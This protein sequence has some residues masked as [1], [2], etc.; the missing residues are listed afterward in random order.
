MN[1]HTVHATTYNNYFVVLRRGLPISEYFNT[2][3]DAQALA[4]KL[5]G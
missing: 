3:E 5:N 4:D 2:R 1:E